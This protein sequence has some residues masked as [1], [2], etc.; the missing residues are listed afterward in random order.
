MSQDDRYRQLA[1][2]SV[3]VAEVVFTPLVLGGL[4]YF[5]ARAHA[6]KIW[7]GMFGALGGLAIAFYRII[8]LMKKQ[9]G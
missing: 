1:L 3:I 9:K 2:F 6:F 8:Q 5:L 7:L 4:L